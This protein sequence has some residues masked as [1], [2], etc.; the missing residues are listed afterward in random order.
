M[1]YRGWYHLFYQYNPEATVGAN[2][3]WGH[4]VSRDLVHWR[5]LPLAMLPDRW[6]DIN[7]VWTSSATMLPNGTLTMLYTGS[8]NASTQV[9]C[10]AVP[11]N[12]NDP[13]LRNWTKHPANPVLLPPPGIGDKD[14]RDPTTAWF[15]KS[16]STWHIAIGSKDDH[17][18]SGIAI[19]YKTKDFVSYELIPGF[20]H[21]VENTGMW[22]CV[23][24]YPVGSRDQDAENS[25]EELL[26]VMKASMDDHR[27]DCYALGRYDAEANMWTPVDPEADVGIGLRYD[28]GRFFA[29][30]TF[31]D[32]A[33]RRRVLLGYVAEADS[34]LADMAKGWACL[35][36]IPRTV[37]LDE[38]TR[39]N[40]LQWPVEE[41]ETLRLNTI[42]LG[43]ITIGTGSIFPLPLRQATQLD[44][45]ASF[46]LDASAVAAFNEVDV[47]YNCSTSGGAASRGTLGPFGL[48]VLT[49]ADSRSEQM[50]VYFYVSKSI[51]G[52]LQTSFCHDESRSS[53]AWDVVK[54]VVGSTVPVLHGEALSVRVL[55]DH[56]I[57]ESF[58]MGGRSTV[59]SRVYPTEAIY[60]AA[61]AYVFNNATGS[62]VTVERLVVHDMDSAFIK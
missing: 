24:F 26:Y 54:R 35:Q 36:S 18:H 16:D 8:T 7:G 40:L 29:S 46:R 61:R 38:K 53:R 39:M 30:K 47:S 41:I 13:L 48:L 58:A 31:Y 9:Q 57:V 33:K 44:M 52:T 6:Y 22:E 28:W 21:R 10:L 55:V 27:H 25:S 12:P 15:H 45:E 50:A 51:D 37:A 43:N 49:T 20:L 1:Y 19:T 5:H 32:P 3:T 14:F 59:T 34:E 62:T 11:A 2:I 23:D 42:D 17:G 60:A 56:S 4:A